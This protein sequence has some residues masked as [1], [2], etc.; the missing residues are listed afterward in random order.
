MMLKACVLAILV[1]SNSCKHERLVP[2]STAP[3][4]QLKSNPTLGSYLSDSL[5]Y[6]LYYFSNDFDG[7]TNC[8]G[9]CLNIWPIYYAGENL[10]Q[11]KL[12]TGLNIADFATI[13]TSSGARQT[14]Y[15]SWPLYYYAP[16]VNGVNVRE[17][18]NETKGE[19]VGNIWFVAKPDYSIMLVNAQLVGNNGKSYKSDYTEGTGRTLYFSDEKGNTLY[20]FKPDSFNINKYTRADFSN[21]AVWPIYETDKVVVPSTLDKTLFGTANVFGKKQ[22]TYK[23]WPIYYFGLDSMKRGLNKGITVPSVGVWPVIVAGMTPAPK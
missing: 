1:F 19:G 12:P 13:T 9:G 15:K 2:T 16:V 4:I 20:G 11:E 21:N 3:L 8:S 7:K 14:T 17:A 5:G 6:T 22:L 18:V 23:G 10:T